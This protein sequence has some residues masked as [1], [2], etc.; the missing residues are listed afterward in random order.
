MC[1]FLEVVMFHCKIVRMSELGGSWLARD[2]VLDP[3]L[4]DAE[5]LETESLQ[6]VTDAEVLIDRI[7]KLS[8]KNLT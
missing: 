7:K 4:E 5:R 3:L 8:Q 6:L 2:H 1:L